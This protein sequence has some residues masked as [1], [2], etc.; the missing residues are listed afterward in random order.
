MA[1]AGFYWCGNERERDSA[2]CFVCDKILDGWESCDDP[3]AEHTK[4]AP[5]C[6]LVKTAKPERDYT[7]KYCIS[8]NQTFKIFFLGRRVH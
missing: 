6:L 7:V 2:S 4:H 5:Q 1:E 3:W 8:S